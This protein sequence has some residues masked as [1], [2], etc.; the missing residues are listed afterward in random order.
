[1]RPTSYNSYSTNLKLTAISG[2][3]VNVNYHTKYYWNN[4]G[5][6][7]IQ[8]VV[9]DELLLKLISDRQD[10][11]TKINDLLIDLFNFFIKLVERKTVLKKL[12]KKQR[13]TIV[14]LIE[15]MKSFMPDIIFICKLFKITERTYYNWK[16]KPV[17][18]ITFTKECPN[19]YPGQLTDRERRILEQEYFFNE[20]YVD[21]SLAD[22]YA[23][24]L[25]DKKVIICDGLFYE[26]ARF[27]G[28][29]EKRKPVY[30]KKYKKG[31]R[32]GK[33]KEIIHMD[34]TLFTTSD[35]KRPWA[36]LIC[37]NKSRAILGLKL[38][39]D[40]RSETA[41]TNLKEAINKHHLLEKPFMLLTDDGSENKGMVKDFTN[42]QAKIDH[43]IAQIDIP[44]SNSMIEAI[45]KQL[46]YRYLK[47]KIFDNIYELEKALIKAV[48]DYNNRPRKM[49]LGKTALEILHGHEQGIDELRELK[50]QARLKRLEENQSFNCMKA[51]YSFVPAD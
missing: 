26:L 17:C 22:L 33:P 27:L 4:S 44:Y 46:K 35:G 21:Y 8:S 40:S 19:I 31:I 6:R 28:E 23:Q 37:D 11:N 16:S 49:H 32:A 9:R 48:Y 47:N 1:M 39:I 51:S 13:A 14:E 34:K 29:A 50:E 24:M 30:K 43:R 7:K 42:S 41:L 18:K 2:E 20:K 12:Y 15:Q 5:R 3:K 25:R 45:I 36:Y 10:I 38:S